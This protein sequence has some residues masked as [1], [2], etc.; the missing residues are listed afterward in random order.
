MRGARQLQLFR[1]IGER[2]TSPEVL[3]SLITRGPTLLSDLEGHLY[4]DLSLIDALPLLSFAARVPLDQIQTGAINQAY[5]DYTIVAG[6]SV[7]IPDRARLS[8]LMLAVFGPGYD[9]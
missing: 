6:D 1:A 5:I 7:A 9:G 2:A 8:E 4:T 3:P